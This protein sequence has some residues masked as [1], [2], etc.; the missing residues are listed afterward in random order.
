MGLSNKQLEDLASQADNLKEN[1]DDAD[2][3]NQ[4]LN[5]MLV[6]M[7]EKPMFTSMND[8]IRFMESDEPLVL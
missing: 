7:G 4:I 5:N 6:T 1:F 8:F 2:K 3:A